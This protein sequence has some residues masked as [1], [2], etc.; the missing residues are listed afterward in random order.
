MKASVNAVNGGRLQEL[1]KEMVERI[2]GGI[3]TVIGYVIY[4]AT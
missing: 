1:R 4:C 3:T 2:D